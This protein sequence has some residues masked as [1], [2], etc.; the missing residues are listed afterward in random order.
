MMYLTT[1]PGFVHEMIS[2]YVRS[3]AY[4]ISGMEEREVAIRTA[5]EKV[6]NETLPVHQRLIFNWVL[7]HARRGKWTSSLTVQGCR[8]W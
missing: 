6:V 5:A 4:S 1:H 8:H 2:G 7:F 3:K